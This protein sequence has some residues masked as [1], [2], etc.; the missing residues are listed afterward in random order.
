[1]RAGDRL[2]DRARED[3][4]RAM[5]IAPRYFGVLPKAGI[6]VKAVEEGQREAE[7]TVRSISRLEESN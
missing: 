3:I 7:E 5:E 1:M 2:L 4:D 6:E